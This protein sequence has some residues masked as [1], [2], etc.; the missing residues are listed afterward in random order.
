MQRRA[1]ALLLRC[2]REAAST[3]SANLFFE[4][5][6]T[7][8]VILLLTWTLVLLLG[9][10]CSVDALRARGPAARAS[11]IALARDAAKKPLFTLAALA[12]LLQA[13]ARFI[14]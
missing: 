7:G 8:C 12:V 10:R 3:F 4:D 5:G 2:L 13:A 9:D 6:G 11:K 1:L 14:G